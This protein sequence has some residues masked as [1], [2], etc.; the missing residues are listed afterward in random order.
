MLMRSYLYLAA[1]AASAVAMAL[2]VSPAEASTGHVLTTGK[3]GGA[4]VKANA[5]LKA[6]LA[7]GKM[8]TF[9]TSG[10]TLTCS[11]ASFSAKVTSNPTKPG[12]AT[13]S[14]TKQSFSKCK[15]SVAG[16]TVKSIKAGNL[17]YSVSVSDK[18]DVVTI[19]GTK[20]KP[21][22]FTAKV[23]VP[24]FGTITCTDTASKITGKASNNG[25][26]I[27]ITK[28]KFKGPG[29]FCV[30]GSFS[31]TFGPVT[32]TSAKGNPKVFVN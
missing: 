10:E 6:G 25:N 31:A 1:A 22:E 27:T 16:A 29:G 17:P 15:V 8:V 9:T 14:L 2:A 30:S 4:A 7:K 18:G 12:K 32:D 28:Q 13:E 3:A 24:G 20:A 19:S 21:L 23:A 5:V 11:S 26:T